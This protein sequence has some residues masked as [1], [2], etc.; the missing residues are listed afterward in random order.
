[1]NVSALA[2][3]LTVTIYMVGQSIAPL[4]WV[5][6]SDTKGRRVVFIASFLVFVIG[7]VGLALTDTYA[8]MMV[9]RL[10]QA[11]GSEALFFVGMYTHHMHYL[12][13]C[14]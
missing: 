1:M 3:Q 13:E 9:F 8:V 6:I 7:N 11:T 5:A 4:V 10:V 12:R 14:V 2:V